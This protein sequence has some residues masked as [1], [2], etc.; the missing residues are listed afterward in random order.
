MQRPGLGSVERIY[1]LWERELR[2]V[3]RLLLVALT[4]ALM[5]AAALLG[6]TGEP[7]SR[8]A[9]IACLL[10]VLVSWLVVGQLARRRRASARSMMKSTLMRTEPELGRAAL[11]A[12][13]LAESTE[14]D[15]RRGSPEL[16]QLHFTRVLGKASLSRLGQLANRRAWGVIAVTLT[17]AVTVTGLTVFEPFRVLEGFNV[18]AA[19]DGRAPIPVRWAETAS[20]QAAPP[21][22]LHWER[23]R[24]RPYF[25][26]A[27]PV[28]SELTVKVRPRYDDRPLVLTDGKRRVDF[29]ESG[30]GFFVARWMVTADSELTIGARFGEVL[31]E[32]PQSFAID[33]VV[34]Q[35]PVVELRDAPSTRRL[36]DEPRIPIHWDV[37][38]DHGL[39]EVTLV[40]RAGD[41]EVR[42]ELSKPQGNKAT[43]RGGIELLAD[44]S[45]LRESF[46][47]VEVTVEALD[48]DVVT[49]PKWGRSEP[50]VLMPPQVAEREAM[51]YRALEG[52]RDALVDVLAARLG[53]YAP[54]PG[55]ASLDADALQEAAFAKIDGL[56]DRD[57]GG[58]RISGRAAAMVEGKLEKLAAEV[59]AA[60][61]L[62]KAARDEKQRAATEG[63]VLVMDS[64][65]GFLGSRDTRES[66]LQ[67][68]DVAD[69]IAEAIGLTGEPGQFDRAQRLINANLVV[70]DAGG[71]FMQ[72]LGTYGRDLG[73]LVENGVRRIKRPLKDRD[74]VHARLAAEDLAARLRRPDPSFGGGG[75]GGGHGHGM[76]QG[77]VE[78]GGG[79]GQPSDGEAS[80]ASEELEGLEQALRQLRQEHSEQMQKLDQ[81]LKDALPAEERQ[82]LQE[83]MREMAKKVREAVDGLPQQASDPESARAEAARGRSEAEGMAGALERGELGEALKRGQ[84]ALES[85]KSAEEKGGR[86]PA[87][88]SERNVGEQAGEARSKL[89]ELAKEGRQAQQGMQDAAAENAGSKLKELAR[90]ERKL[91]EK[92]EQLQ[93]QSEMSEAPLPR[94]M[95]RRLED[96]ARA[97]RDAANQLE[98]G[99]GK[100][101]KEK[102]EQAQRMLEMAQP[103]SED[104]GKG[105]PGDG[106]D[107]DRE[108]DVPPE[109][110]DQRADA[111]RKRVTD[112]LRRDAPP[113]LREALRRYTE[114]LLR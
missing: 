111:F 100:E 29:V 110:R 79:M 8:G 49:G 64:A 14:N 70:L 63:A 86:A 16:A 27:L 20:L 87:G 69:T 54:P 93:R 18:L 32:E 56:L 88:S 46:L 68:A 36:F 78:S 98:R 92:A 37:S 38:D 19:R 53:A 41:R 106:N 90:K 34:D 95:R 55:E 66:A 17:I 97:M 5:V 39:R 72:Q 76:G 11:R 2:P 59:K 24:L 9:A 52:G 65:L 82:A 89:D 96:A 84:S 80:Q 10:S 94:A 50:M 85:L 51:R 25:P 48:N 4:A 91:G 112:G 45:F 26:H 105:Q 101:G 44:D 74:W 77:G 99:N 107:F 102:Q 47:P 114:G 61:L 6:R 35:A 42:R 43:D 71:G 113:H 40:L 1:S 67:L 81:A 22:Y 13:A 31:V 3:T 60:A 7:W 73:E 33:A 83:K 75:S 23:T 62:P 58:I 57:Y 30:A 12:M 21:A 103:E 15:A 109:A 28:G 108:A 104:R